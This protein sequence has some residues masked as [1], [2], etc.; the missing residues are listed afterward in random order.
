[1]R[2]SS[3]FDIRVIRMNTQIF[4]QFLYVQKLCI[5]QCDI[6]ER[7]EFRSLKKPDFH[8]YQFPVPYLLRIT[9]SFHFY[10][11]IC[12]CK[13]NLH[14]RCFVV[15]EFGLLKNVKSLCILTMLL[16]WSSGKFASYPSVNYTSIGV[17]KEVC[18]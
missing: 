5:M 4:L 8:C 17:C 12:G 6:S 2:A 11:R 14:K 7:M 18:R 13:I 1:M 10:L 16:Q 9:L 15:Q 3:P